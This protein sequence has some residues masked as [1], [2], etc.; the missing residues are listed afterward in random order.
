MPKRTAVSNS[1]SFFWQGGV[2]LLSKSAEL[3]DKHITVDCLL[4]CI[5]DLRDAIGP[6]NIHADVR[7]VKTAKDE[8]FQQYCQA[9]ESLPIDKLKKPAECTVESILPT[10]AELYE[11]AY[12]THQAAEQAIITDRH[13]PREK[14]RGATFYAEKQLLN[15][16]S[17]AAFYEG[18]LHIFSTKLPSSVK[19]VLE[20]YYDCPVVS[21]RS[22]LTR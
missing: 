22:S 4:D 7:L 14:R 21:V 5:S 2:P 18:Q 15:P 19:R 12:Q 17:A 11:A 13:M 6:D 3:R 20:Y 9:I 1:Y 8:V 10:L 16:G